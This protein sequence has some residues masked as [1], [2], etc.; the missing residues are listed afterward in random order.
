M[1]ASYSKM[2]D[3]RTFS[4][5]TPDSVVDEQLRH[6]ENIQT[7]WDYRIYLQENA[8][9]I[10]KLNQAQSFEHKMPIYV[11]GPNT[12]YTFK[13]DEQGNYSDLKQS[14]LSREELQKR[15]KHTVITQ[16][17]LLMFSRSH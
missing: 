15:M 7:N 16:E 13:G 9:S 2:A 8:S 17:E 4:N 1:W 11:Q 12:P 6:R 5:Y 3:G 14:Y 10:M